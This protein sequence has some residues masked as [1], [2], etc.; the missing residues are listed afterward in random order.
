M[1]EVQEVFSGTVANHETFSE[2]MN[3]KRGIQFEIPI[4]R[5]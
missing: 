1:S 4:G 5:P 3:R 2:D